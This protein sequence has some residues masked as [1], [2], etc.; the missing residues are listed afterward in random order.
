MVRMRHKSNGDRCC[1]SNG[2]VRTRFNNN[3]AADEPYRKAKTRS[4]NNHRSSHLPLALCKCGCGLPV[5]SGSTWRPGHHN[6]G[7]GNGMYGHKNPNA[8][9]P[10]TYEPYRCVELMEYMRSGLS[11]TQAAHKMGVWDGTLKTWVERFPEFAMAMERGHELERAWWEEKG[12]SNLD[13]NKFNTALYVFMTANKFGWS[14]TDKLQIEQHSKLE[15]EHT[16][17]GKVKLDADDIGSV[18]AVFNIL[19]QSGAI[20]AI[21]REQSHIAQAADTQDDQV[22]LTYPNG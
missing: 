14:R 9:R 5:K 8:G 19:V 2:R 3:H 11:R 20:A 21:A 1:S 10:S 7:R 17:T 22:L 13:N 6:K 18:T 15:H 16:H 4:N 12:R